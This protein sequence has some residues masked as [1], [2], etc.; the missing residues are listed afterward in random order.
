MVT[1]KMFW[2]TV[3]IYFIWIFLFFWGI[4]TRKC[5]YMDSKGYRKE[6]IGMFKIRIII[7]AERVSI[8]FVFR[9]LWHTYTHVFFRKYHKNLLKKKRKRFVKRKLGWF[10]FK[11][12][13]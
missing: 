1:R 4:H 10:S 5:A 3:S 2:G 6:I 11:Y 7:L 9:L 8:M 12:I 13:F